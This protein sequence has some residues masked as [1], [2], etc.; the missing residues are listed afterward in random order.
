MWTCICWLH[1]QFTGWVMW[2]R[3]DTPPCSSHVGDSVSHYFRS[4][5]P[6]LRSLQRHWDLHQSGKSWPL[7]PVSV[8]QVSIMLH[9]KIGLK[10]AHVKRSCDQ[11]PHE[12]VISL[13]LFYFERMSRKEAWLTL[14]R[15]Q[16]WTSATASRYVPQRSLK[17]TSS[18]VWQQCQGSSVVGAAA[19]QSERLVSDPGKF[20]F[21]LQTSGEYC[22]DRATDCSCHL[23]SASSRWA[24]TSWTE[25]GSKHC[26]SNQ[27]PVQQA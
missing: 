26:S 8:M 16:T 4:E 6:D 10:F 7:S 9:M 23:C 19:S 25:N 3:C 11:W 18:R 22:C 5:F 27:K 12:A 13:F 14:P 17:V 15:D 24:A 1:L 20:N 2:S 21:L